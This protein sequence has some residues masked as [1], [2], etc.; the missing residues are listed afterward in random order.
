MSDDMKFRHEWKHEITYADMFG[1][2]S[3]VETVV[4]MSR[5]DK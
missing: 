3:H 5:K 2:R 1:L 4:L